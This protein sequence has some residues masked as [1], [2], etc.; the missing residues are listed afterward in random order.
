MRDEDFPTS[1]SIKQAYT[2]E[3]S[4]YFNPYHVVA[5]VLLNCKVN[6]YTIKNMDVLFRTGQ[7]DMMYNEVRLRIDFTYGMPE[8]W[9]DHM[10]YEIERLMKEAFTQSY[11]KKADKTYHDYHPPLYF[12][13]EFN[14]AEKIKP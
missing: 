8:E 12:D 4:Q 7:N 3:M 5:N 6:P 11:G 10:K 9:C 13:K 1:I 2:Q 14:E